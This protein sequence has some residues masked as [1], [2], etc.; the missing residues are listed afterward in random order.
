MPTLMQ[1]VATLTNG[2]VQRTGRRV[3]RVSAL[4][5][6]AMVFITIG[7]TG[8]SLAAFLLLARLLDPILAALLLGSLF[9]LSGAVL[10]WVAAAQV[11]PRNPAFVSPEQEPARQ[12]LA[13][14]LRVAGVPV[15]LIPVLMAAVFGFLISNRK[16]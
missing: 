9:C 7:M 14:L 2:A 3:A 12:D 10:L 8:L 1:W 15:V 4:V 16:R 11:R 6:L 5:V 13:G